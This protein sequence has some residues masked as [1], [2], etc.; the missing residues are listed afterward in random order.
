MCR[1]QAHWMFCWRYWKISELLA[2]VTN[3][4]SKCSLRCINATNIV[5]VIVIGLDV[6]FCTIYW[7]VLDWDSSSWV[8]NQY[9][10]M[11]ILLAFLS[12]AVLLYA[13]IRMRLILK[14]RSDI[15]MNVTYITLLVATV[16]L[17]DCILLA[18]NISYFVNT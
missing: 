13:I 15:S 6:T 16:V 17:L 3:T 8:V 10:I 9:V 14:N 11:Q 4:P 2:Q 1:L 5:V 12:T 7:V 18:W